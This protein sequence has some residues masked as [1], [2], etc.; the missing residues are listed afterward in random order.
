[1]NSIDKVA[2][3]SRSFSHNESLRNELL[4]KYKNVTFN[5][6]GLSLDGNNLIKFLSDHNKAIVALEKISEDILIKL[7]NL[8]VISKYGVGL[9]MIEM[10]SLKK[11]G[12][13][14]GWTGGVNK[15]SVSEMVVS[16]AISLLRSVPEA[17]R[18]VVKGEWRQQVGG[19]LSNRIFGIVGCG[20][21]G[22]DL[23]KLLQPFGCKIIVND[24]LDYKD[25]FKKY[26]IE[27][28]SLEDLL[29]RSDVV[30]LHVPLDDSTRNM[31]DSKRLKLLKPGSILINL[32]RGGLIDEV[33]L[34]YMLMNK[35]LL[36]AAID[37]FS[38]EPP[39][40]QEFLSLPNIIV[41]PHIG[42]SSAEAILSMGRAAIEGLDNNS[43]P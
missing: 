36:A 37:V 39:E 15:R 9:D 10:E 43:V 33:Y 32:A 41:T 31:L 24:I 29:V 38:T 42:G 28:A 23:V 19:L 6:Q 8:K 30:S 4:Q 5:D 14:F 2:V 25:F 27:T 13:R 35:K 34:K 22:K 11:F 17:H 20:F 16:N 21:I 12:V 3:C 1:M 7:P 40:D 26:N 18:K